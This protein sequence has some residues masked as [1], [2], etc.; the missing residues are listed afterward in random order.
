M[1]RKALRIIRSS[2]EALE[3]VTMRLR[4]LLCSLPLLSLSLLSTAVRAD[5]LVGV[6]VANELFG[7]NIEAAGSWGSVYAVLGSYQ[8]KTGFNLFENVTGYVGYRGYLDNKYDQD[9]YFGGFF[10]G[11]VAGGDNY[12]RYGAGGEIGYQWVS[13]TL[14]TELHGGLAIV[15]EATGTGVPLVNEVKPQA[16]IGASVSL[17]FH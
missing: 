6:S 5:T 7:A 17:R 1:G 4:A 16:I 12:N 13:D 11:D 15:G 9:N 10:I 2:P 8:A 14:R 3:S